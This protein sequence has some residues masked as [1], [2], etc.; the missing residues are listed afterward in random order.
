MPLPLS[1]GGWDILLVQLRQEV[2]KQYT[3][4]REPFLD[5]L[6]GS[7]EEDRTHRA[8]SEIEDDEAKVRV[9]NPVLAGSDP[10]QAAWLPTRG[11]IPSIPPRELFAAIKGPHNLEPKEGLLMD[12]FMVESDRLLAMSAEE[13]KSI[14]YLDGWLFKFVLET[15]FDF[16]L[17]AEKVLQFRSLI[18]KHNLVFDYDAATG[19]AFNGQ[20]EVDPLYLQYAG[21]VAGTW[22]GSDMDL[23]S[24]SNSGA[25]SPAAAGAAVSWSPRAA[26]SPQGETS[27]KSSSGRSTPPS[28]SPSSNNSNSLPISPRHPVVFHRPRYIDWQ[29]FTMQQLKQSGFFTACCVIASDYYSQTHGGYGLHSSQGTQVKDFSKELLEF[30]FDVGLAMPVAGNTAFVCNEGWLFNNVVGPL[31]KLAV[32]AEQRKKIILVTT[33]DYREPVELIG[34]DRL[35]VEVGGILNL[36][37]GNGVFQKSGTLRFFRALIKEGK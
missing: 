21:T 36:E 32:S 28:G 27:S 22:V 12:S 30:Q 11:D 33:E 5:E 4:L 35:P 31:L 17:A 29:S 18:Q 16:A 14:S 25:M 2:H 34:R 19:A 10:F 9:A 37:D 1:K 20:L 8:D 23:P 3:A 7:T 15:N 13:I 26:R 24:C 6:L